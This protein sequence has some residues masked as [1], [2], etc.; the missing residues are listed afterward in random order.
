MQWQNVMKDIGLSSRMVFPPS[1]SLLTAKPDAKTIVAHHESVAERRAGSNKTTEP[2]SKVANNN[3]GHWQ[4][5]FH[6]DL[7]I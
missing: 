2:Q 1:G 3:T 7:N 5:H 6:V 4:T